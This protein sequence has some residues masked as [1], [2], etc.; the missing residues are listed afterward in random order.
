MHDLSRRVKVSKKVVAFLSISLLVVATLFIS[1]TSTAQWEDYVIVQ[2]PQP[3]EADE[4][5]IVVGGMWGD[6]CAPQYYYHAIYGNT[7]VI[8]AVAGPPPGVACAPVIT[9]WEFATHIGYLPAGSYTVE[10]RILSLGGEEYPPSFGYFSV[11]PKAVITRL[12]LPL[13]TTSE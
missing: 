13:L 3:T 2:P 10:L 4:I 7:L 12:Y 6:S 8:Y 1:S 5:S 9:P 11:L